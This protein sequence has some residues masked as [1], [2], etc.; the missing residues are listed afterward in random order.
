MK[1]L[2]LNQDGN[3]ERVDSNKIL[4]ILTSISV[5]RLIFCS[6]SELPGMDQV[7]GDQW[8]VMMNKIDTNLDGNISFREYQ[9]YSSK[10]Q[11][12]QGDE[13]EGS[14]AEG[15]GGQQGSCLLYTSDAADE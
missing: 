3:L 7:P 15:S 10:P 8:A 6:Q 14:Q 13:L 1:A 2:D 11:A 4:Y 9:E 12:T 5:I